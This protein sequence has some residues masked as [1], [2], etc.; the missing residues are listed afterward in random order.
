[1]EDELTPLDAAALYL[2]PYLK[3]MEEQWGLAFTLILIDHDNGQ[4]ANL[5]NFERV[6]D[7]MFWDEEEVN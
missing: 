7:G 1:M 6:R 5:S 4:S 2:S 3:H